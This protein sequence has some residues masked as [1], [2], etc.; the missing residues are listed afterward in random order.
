M[1]PQHDKQLEAR[2]DRVLK[3][4]PELT[5]PG[6]LMPRV[7]AAIAARQ[8]LPWYRQPWIVWPVS[9]RFATMLFLLASFGSLCI[10]SFELTRAA[11]LATAMQEVSQTFSGLSSI[12]NVINV[13]LSAVV[14]VIKHL[15]T[16]FIIACCFA[17][18]LAYAIC[19]GLGTAC[20]RLAYAR[21]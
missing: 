6:T 12:W 21:K 4:L 13:L 9:L 8:A 14:L 7:L 10:A 2:I 18:A 5:A 17:A 19:V 15:G 20:V 3:E 16:G 11:G 1:N